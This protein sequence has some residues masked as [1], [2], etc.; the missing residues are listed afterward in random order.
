MR[1]T[2]L[3]EGLASA[4]RELAQRSPVPVKIEVTA[5]RF[6]AEIEAAAYF[7]ASEALTNA[8]KHAGASHV[9]CMR[10]SRTGAW[11]CE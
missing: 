4:L 1:P 6:A 2:R 5:E 3:D 7:V 11:S 10:V 8:A 9:A